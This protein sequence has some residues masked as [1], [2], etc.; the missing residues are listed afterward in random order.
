MRYNCLPSC[1]Y[2]PH[3][4]ISGWYL[5]GALYKCVCFSSLSKERLQAKRIVTGEVSKPEEKESNPA[6]TGRET[7]RTETSDNEGTGKPSGRQQRR[8]ARKIKDEL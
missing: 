6:R 2:L 4:N 1:K 8:V 3:L 5:H 7:S